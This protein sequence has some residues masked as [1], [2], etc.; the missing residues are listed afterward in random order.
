MSARPPRAVSFVPLCS[1]ALLVLSL[2]ATSRA[3]TSSAPSDDAPPRTPLAGRVA[4]TLPTADVRVDARSDLGPLEAWR[5]GAGH[6]GINSRPLP[7]PV[8]RGL[9]KLRPRLTRIF[10]Q[11]FFDIYPERGRFDWSRL[12]PYMDALTKTG[13]KVVAAITLKPKPLFP[14][15]DQEVWRP[16]DVDEWRRVVAAL[17][18]RYSVDRPIVTHWEVGN[19]TDIGENGGCPYLI[20]DPKDYAEYY[21][22]TVPAILEAFPG[23]KVGG[24]AVANSNS[25]Y[26]PRFI[27]QARQE[28]LRLDFVSWHL[29]ADSPT[30][31]AGLVA[32]YRKL[33]EPFGDARPE[34]MVTE[35]SKSFDRASIEEMAFDPRRAAVT[36]AC[37]IAYLDA[38]VDWTFYYHAWDQVAY[39]D[40]FRPFFAKPLI[41]YHHWNEAPHRFGLFG[42]DRRVRPQ[43]FAFQMLAR[44]G[45]RR[46]EATS[47]EKGLRVLAAR[48]GEVPS[49]M[50]VNGGPD[51]S[52]DVRSKL[53]FVNLTP[54]PRQLVVRRIDRDLAWSA[55]DLELRPAEHRDVDVAE[56]FACEV[57]CPAD[58]VTFV[59]LE[60][61]Q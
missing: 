35:W 41:M 2:A 18:K 47:A 19:E 34:M 55:R 5:H 13:A 23:A 36:A 29:Y 58:S 31:H 28:K 54:G 49:V 17:V 22:L 38:K 40:E 60:K 14:A 43:Y 16:N 26:L 20:K 61:P 11:Q 51:A 9:A 25:D 57:Y 42:V 33:L 37:L 30:A 12:D 10:I 15:V 7:D 56:Q 53:A 24:T 52:K 32:K 44:L 50:I 45:E 8:I 3:Q 21:K 4:A 39:F 46:I 6:G 59:S 27:E 1:L 48:T